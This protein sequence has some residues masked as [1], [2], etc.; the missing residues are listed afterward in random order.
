ML[1]DLEAFRWNVGWQ[2][3]LLFHEWFW[4]GSFLN[5][6]R[7]T[8]PKNFNPWVRGS[9]Q[10]LRLRPLPQTGNAAFCISAGSGVY[11]NNC[12]RLNESQLMQKYCEMRIKSVRL[13]PVLFASRYA[14][15]IFRFKLPL[16]ELPEKLVETLWE[17]CLVRVL[18]HW[19]DPRGFELLRD[20]ALM[21]KKTKWLIWLL[22]HRN[23]YFRTRILPNVTQTSPPPVRRW[24]CWVTPGNVAI[25]AEVRFSWR[26][27]TFNEGL[28]WSHT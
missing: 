15:L 14:H 23:K 24:S 10:E 20:A 16:E 6:H 22:P 17:V 27:K 25:S 4:S 28:S 13:L 7:C 18:Q 11:R 19:H 26:I 2:K 1:P 5:K 3:R 21:N 12:T 8:P 9:L